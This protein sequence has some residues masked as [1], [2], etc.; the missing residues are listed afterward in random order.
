VAHDDEGRVTAVPVDVL[1]AGIPV[2]DFPA[3][4]TW[5]DRLFGRPA[6]IVVKDDEVMW[7]VADAAWVYVVEDR[8]RVGNALV[9]M[10]V[11]DL[12]R[13]MAEIEDRG[14]TGASIEIVAGAG[15][16]ASMAD[17]DGNTVTFIEVDPH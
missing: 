5:Y 1:F 13:A 17:P 15:R 6:D 8:K 11:P 14:I 9:T 10:A 4:V 3:A 16:K 12:E 2:V 7:R